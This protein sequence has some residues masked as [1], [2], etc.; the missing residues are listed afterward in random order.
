MSRSD[1]VGVFTQNFT[2]V[3]PRARIIRASIEEP[4]KTMEHPLETGAVITDHRIIQPIRIELSTILQASDYKST[5]RQI[6]QLFLNGTLLLVQT[7]SSVYR[8]QLIAE[9]PHEE[10]PSMFDAL[11]VAIKL[12]E[13]QFVSAQFGIVPQNPKDSASVDRGQVQPK[14]GG[15]GS[16]LS[17]LIP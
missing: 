5:Y 11:A 13:A 4:S 10:D 6:K 7:K 2:Q 3:F 8:N 1:E 12:K 9:M 14:P 17:G 16:I 15:Q